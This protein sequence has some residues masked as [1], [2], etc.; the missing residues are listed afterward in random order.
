MIETI[1]APPE[2]VEIANF[3]EQNVLECIP[4]IEMSDLVQYWLDQSSK[5]VASATT[6]LPVHA[7]Q[8]AGGTSNKAIPLAAY[9]VLALLAARI[10]DD[11][12][13]QESDVRPW[14]ND[15]ALTGIPFGIAALTAANASLTFL[16]VSSDIRTVV[17]RK[18]HGA[19]LVA[20]RAQSREP[21]D[22]Q[23]DTY[24]SNAIGSSGL[25][26]GTIA[27][28]GGRLATDD[29]DTQKRLHDIGY[30]IG[31]RDAVRSDCADLEE[32][33]ERGIFTLPV[34][35]AKSLHSHPLHYRLTH[36]LAGQKLSCNEIEEI[37]SILVKMDATTWSLHVSDR[38]HEKAVT[39]LRELDPSEKSNLWRYVRKQP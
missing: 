15:G 14:N 10:L 38:F 20:A 34:V 2:L 22:M 30:Y 35:Y 29:E 12:Q 37:Q 26:F 18:L 24:F 28:A 8:A 4:W 7:Y 33:L 16:D 17:E 32:D 19:V 21:R 13:D 9:W 1:D 6:L 3:I 31:M 5:G 27:W 39:N 36:L 23:L 11:V 25:A